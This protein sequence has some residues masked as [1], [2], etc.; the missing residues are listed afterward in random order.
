[1]S[2]RTVGVVWLVATLACAAFTFTYFD[3]YPAFAHG[4]RDPPLLAARTFALAFLFASAPFL[5]LLALVT[6]EAGPVAALDCHVAIYAVFLFITAATDS[7]GHSSPGEAFRGVILFILFAILGVEVLV[8]LVA[9]GRMED[10][11]GHSGCRPFIFIGVST[12]LFGGWML[13]VLAWSAV[14]V[15]QV[16]AAAEAAAGDRPYCVDVDGRAARSAFNFSA[17]S[18]HGSNNGSLTVNFHALLV[19][20]AGADRAYMNWSYRSGRFEPLNEAARASLH[21]DA[22]AKCA[23]VAH[24]AASLM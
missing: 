12:A 19:I 9:H 14:L 17:L 11:A 23:P 13:G 3:H 5:C 21:L 20:G 6:R 10:P 2:V 8:A 18:M 7:P 1:M 22:Q 24:F 4:S 15:P 16:I